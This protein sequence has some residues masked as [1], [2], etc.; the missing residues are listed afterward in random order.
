MNEFKKKDVHNV[1]NLKLISEIISNLDYF[2]FFGT[3]LGIIRENTLISGDDDIDFLI[4]EKDVSTL[5]KILLSNNFVVTKESNDYISFRNI[6]LFEEHTIDFYKFYLDGGYIYIPGSFYS[7]CKFNLKRHNLKI[8]KNI[9]LPSCTNELNLKI[10]KDSKKVLIY[11]YGKNWKKSLKKNEE[12]F[13]Y[14]RKNVPQI[15]YNIILVNLLYLFRL[16]A[17]G[18]YKAA[19]RFFIKKIGLYKYINLFRQEYSEE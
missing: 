6:D 7:N 16:I 18:R 12:Y 3:L 9:M 5:K 11:I 4:N 14:F 1:K 8:P 19:R 15:T 2:I 10:P 13:I 17:E